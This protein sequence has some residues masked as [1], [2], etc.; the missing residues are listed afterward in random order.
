ML[1]WNS[2]KLQL[3]YLILLISV[4]CLASPHFWPTTRETV[5]LFCFFNTKLGYCSG[6]NVLFLQNSLGSVINN[7]SYFFLQ[8]FLLFFS[9]SKT[10]SSTLFLLL[11]FLNKFIFQIFH[12]WKPNWKGLNNRWIAK[13]GEV[14]S[15]QASPL[16]LNRQRFQLKYIF[17]E[18]HCEIYLQS[19]FV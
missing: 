12:L 7:K 10:L 11:L 5:L 1:L 16:V 15:H 2:I 3:I 8:R 19:C 13:K 6:F 4:F 17:W 9:F 14:F 18:P